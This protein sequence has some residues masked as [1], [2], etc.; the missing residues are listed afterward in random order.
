[1]GFVHLV[2]RPAR[3]SKIE[4]LRTTKLV[5]TCP[6]VGV[7]DVPTSAQQV[8]GQ[9]HRTYKNLHK[10]THIS[11]ICLL[12]VA[13]HT[14]AGL[15]TRVERL[16][17]LVVVQWALVGRPHICRHK[18]CRYLRL[19][20]GTSILYKPWNKYAIVAVT[21]K[22]SQPFEGSWYIIGLNYINCSLA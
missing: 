16:R 7:D 15:V 10:M 1:M 17:T 9:G 18:A 21:K 2:V 19:L 8:K 11:R 3:N 5:W 4:R 20:A 6:R 22:F 14:L 13:D 12:T